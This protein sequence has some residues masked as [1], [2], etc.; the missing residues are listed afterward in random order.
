MN[1]NTKLASNDFRS[2]LPRF[3]PEAMKANQVLVDRLGRIAKKKNATP[4]QIAIAWLLGQKPWIVPIP[5]TTKLHRL[6]EK[7]CLV[8][9]P[10][11][12]IGARS[13]NTHTWPW[14]TEIRV[15]SRVVIFL[16][17]TRFDK[18]RRGLPRH[19]RRALRKRRV[20]PRSLTQSHSS[21]PEGFL[22]GHREPCG[23]NRCRTTESYRC[24]RLTKIGTT[25][26]TLST[27]T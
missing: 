7:R 24:G 4:A 6:E 5:G 16:A 11:S 19:R 3:T 21:L 12:I 17:G 2:I 22:S 13:P 26:E 27:R 1:E 14:A 18:S 25:F 10:I 20:N 8:A 15:R 9:R 23:S